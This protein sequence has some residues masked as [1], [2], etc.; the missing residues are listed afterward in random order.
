MGPGW[1]RDGTRTGQ[2][3]AE[4]E[5][6]R[7]TALQ[8][9]AARC[10]AR[11]AR[12]RLCSC[13]VKGSWRLNPSLTSFTPA[14]PP[15]RAAAGP[16]ACSCP[17][18]GPGEQ[19]EDHVLRWGGDAYRCSAPACPMTV[20]ANRAISSSHLWDHNFDVTS[21]QGNSSRAWETLRI[22]AKRH[23]GP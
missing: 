6:Q 15:C 10:H 4:A 17:R 2:P 14:A 11:V 5:N 3:G 13:R 8:G 9:S 20:T 7:N 18:A 16:S 21:R 23:S 1:D 19:R 22:D 12:A